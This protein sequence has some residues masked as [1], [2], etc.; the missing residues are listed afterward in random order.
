MTKKTRNK[1]I[2]SK[3][4]EFEYCFS[5]IISIYRTLFAPFRNIYKSQNS[6]TT[7]FSYLFT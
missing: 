4:I 2:S 6:D 5:F 7:Y 3:K 1:S